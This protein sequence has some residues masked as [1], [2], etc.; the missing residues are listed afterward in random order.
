MKFIHIYSFICIYFIWSLHEICGLSA[1]REMDPSFALGRQTRCH[2]LHISKSCKMENSRCT[3]STRKER[4]VSIANMKMKRQK[5]Y[6]GLL[7]EPGIPLRL[8]P[9]SLLSILWFDPVVWP[10]SDSKKWTNLS[11]HVLIFFLKFVKF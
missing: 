4:R 8:N 7:V 5:C 3:K 10:P 2:I 9:M 1:A 11:Q 6:E